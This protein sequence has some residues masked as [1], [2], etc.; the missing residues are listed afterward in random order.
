MD[1]V[2]SLEIA[3]E[4]EKEGKAFFLKA[5]AESQSDLAKNIFRELARQEDFHIKKILEIY[6][7]MKKKEAVRE[8]VTTVIDA[9]RLGKVFEESLVDKARGSENDI[10]AMQF[11]LQIEDKSIKYYEGLAA[12]AADNREKRFYLTLSAE[13]RGHYLR[14][15]DSIEYLSDPVGWF[16]VKQ[17]SMVDGG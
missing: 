12:M 5:A 3:V 1:K 11:G 7:A 17:G 10:K 4:M 8:W 14:I 13:E 9:D 16:Y 15:M 6:D 2:N